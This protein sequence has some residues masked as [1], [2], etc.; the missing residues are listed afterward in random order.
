[1]V[2]KLI[3]IVSLFVLNQAYGESCKEQS[4]GGEYYC[5]ILLL[6]GLMVHKDPLKVK[7]RS[8]ETG[9]FDLESLKSQ[10]KSCRK[11]VVSFWRGKFQE[12]FGERIKQMTTLTYEYKQA[13]KMEISDHNNDYSKFYRGPLTALFKK[14]LLT[15]G[16]V[17]SPD[18]LELINNQK[19]TVVKSMVLELAVL[20][21]RYN[22]TKV[23]LSKNFEVIKY[24]MGKHRWI[25]NRG[26]C[27]VRKNSSLVFPPLAAISV[28]NNNEGILQIL[29]K[30]NVDVKDGN[31]YAGKLAKTLKREKLYQ[32]LRMS[33]KDKFL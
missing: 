6:E 8:E 24:D 7:F 17:L 11:K 21:N 26:S 16:Y 29:S 3:I 12:K 23:L 30:S 19:D 20:F 33:L 1:M 22:L 28:M 9:N 13:L 10:Y 31:S 5:E 2:N 25:T 32:Y 18:D 27:G 14:M 15:P 4:L